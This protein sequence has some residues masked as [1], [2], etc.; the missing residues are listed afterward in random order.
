VVDTRHHNAT[1]HDDLAHLTDL[2]DRMWHQLP[3]RALD[4]RALELTGGAVT[5]VVAEQQLRGIAALLLTLDT[6]LCGR[7]RRS[8]DAAAPRSADP[9]PSA[10]PAQ[11]NGAPT[12]TRPTAGLAAAAARY[13]ARDLAARQLSEFTSAEGYRLARELARIGRDEQAVE[14]LLAQANQIRLHPVALTEALSHSPH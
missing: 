11:R 1:V 3:A 7:R 6:Y 14:R 8:T 4:D 10:T 13:I 9:A 12:A 5:P 2:V